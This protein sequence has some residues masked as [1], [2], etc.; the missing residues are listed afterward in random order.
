MLNFFVAMESILHAG[1]SMN[2]LEPVILRQ[3]AHSICGFSS[4][5]ISTIRLIDPTFGVD[6]V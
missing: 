3:C 6:L 4:V 1:R 5:L 2:L